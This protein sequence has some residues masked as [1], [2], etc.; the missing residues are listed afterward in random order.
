MKMRGIEKIN[1]KMIT[2][3]IRGC[4]ENSVVRKEFFDLLKIKDE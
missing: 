4:F 1:S 3:S 2:S